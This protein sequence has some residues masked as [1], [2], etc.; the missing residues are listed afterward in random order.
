MKNLLQKQSSSGQGPSASSNS[1]IEISEGLLGRVP[2][3]TES[4]ADMMLFDS[5]VNVY[6]DSNV[7]IPE[8]DFRSRQVRNIP[9]GKKF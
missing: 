9:K 3:E 7:Y 2:D 1:G 4:I 8:F 6:G 5:D